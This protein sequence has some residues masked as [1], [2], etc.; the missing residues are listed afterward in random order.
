MKKVLSVTV[1]AVLF[2][3]IFNV[4]IFATETLEEDSYIG[5]DDEYS[6]DNYDYD[7]SDYESIMGSGYT[8]EELEEG[9][10]TQMELLKEQYKEYERSELVKAKVTS[11]NEMDYEYVTDQYNIY[12]DWSQKIT[13]EILEG[14]YKGEQ[15][16]IE[17]P[18]TIDLVGNIK[19]AEVS[20]GD[21]IYVY[22]NS[23]SEGETPT[24]GIM[25]IDTSVNRSTAFIVLG[26]I[27]ALLILVYGGKH[28][29]NTIVMI[30]LATVLFFFTLVPSITNEYNII[31]TTIFAASLLIIANIVLKI[32]INKKALLALISSI[33]VLIFISALFYGFTYMG[34]ITG[35]TFEAMVISEMI[36]YNINFYHLLMSVLLIG[37][38]VIVS[39]IA[40]NVANAVEEN[41]SYNNRA[42]RVLNNSKEIIPN[43]LNTIVIL[44]LSILIPKYLL[45][46]SYKYP[47]KELM[48]SEMF[49]S[50][51]SRI[52]II[53]IAVCVTIPVTL[54]IGQLIYG[55][56]SHKIAEENVQE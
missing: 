48:N 27:S 46:V 24:P 16:D 20:K 7:Y 52:L 30:I 21:I 19:L 18:I 31:I 47:F 14:D 37:V 12:K 45:L 49:I 6:E 15:F 4:S 10:N 38:A 36:I 11:M 17:Y 9:Y 8:Q 43:Y 39:N 35:N 56:E 3:L 5:Y 42:E 55:K 29:I 23:T 34:K 51:I 40:C 25:T 22:F 41:K 28:G 54:L 44:L 33:V 26:I 1:L 50:E 2:L 53:I 32:G 13:I